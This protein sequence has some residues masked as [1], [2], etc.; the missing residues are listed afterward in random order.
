M[1]K[2]DIFQRGGKMFKTHKEHLQGQL[3]S[4]FDELGKK[5]LKKLKRSWAKYFYE[6]VF[7]NIDEEKFRV[8][9][10][11]NKSRP[12]SPINSMVAS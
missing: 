9:Y 4:Q 6:L 10:S 11:Q 8:I 2:E 5:K 3:F 1:E 7:C 12:N